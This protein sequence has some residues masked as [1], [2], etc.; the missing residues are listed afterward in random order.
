LN[1][2]LAVT[3]EHQMT[4][5]G[6]IVDGELVDRHRS[7]WNEDNIQ[8]FWAGATF[9][10]PGESTELSYSLAE[11]LVSLLLEKGKPLENFIQAANWSDAGQDAALSTL[12]EGVDNL[13]VEFLG[14]GNWRPQRKAIKEILQALRTPP[15]ATP[16][17][18]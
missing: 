11:V 7:Y 13:V 10:V 2:G 5:H 18:P 12:E 8:E 9:W 14:P 6:P 4:Q 1:E 17:H 15:K 16:P 3:I